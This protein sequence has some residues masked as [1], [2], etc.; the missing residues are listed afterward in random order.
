MTTKKVPRIS[1]ASLERWRANLNLPSNSL[2]ISMPYP[3]ARLP[4]F[5]GV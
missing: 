3:T 2:G 1:P 4:P 5:S